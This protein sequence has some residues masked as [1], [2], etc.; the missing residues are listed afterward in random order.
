MTRDE[1]SAGSPRRHWL[2]FTVGLFVL[3]VFSALA[4]WVMS[5][6]ITAQHR[7]AP[8]ASHSLT[9]E[10]A[11]DQACNAYRVASRQWQQAYA[12]WLPVVTG[13]H[14]QWGDRAVKS[15]T[16][17]F[18]QTESAIAAQLESLIPPNTPADVAQAIRSYTGALLEYSAGHGVASDAQ[19]DGQENQ[20]DDAADSV[21]AA[22]D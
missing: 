4:G 1:T 3:V 5:G 21:A 12:E 17:R 7:P 18:M 9:E 8:V 22:C 15:A 6:L 13:P 20:I 10:Q 16:N 2:L 19:M 11:R 14:W